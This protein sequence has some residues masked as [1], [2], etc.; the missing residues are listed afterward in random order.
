MKVFVNNYQQ[1]NMK[2]C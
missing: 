1:C 2:F